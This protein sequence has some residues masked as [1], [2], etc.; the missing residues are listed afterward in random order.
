MPSWTIWTTGVWTGL[1]VASK[2]NVPST[3]GTSFS[4]A[5]ALRMDRESLALAFFMA[6]AS[7][8]TP[9]Y[10]WAANWS[11]SLLYWSR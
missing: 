2:E 8:Y 9:A 11:G 7:R 10:A 5:R 6:V 1:R 3:V 4:C